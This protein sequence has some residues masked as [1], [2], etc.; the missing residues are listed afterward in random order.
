MATDAQDSVTKIPAGAVAGEAVLIV[1]FYGHS[2]RMPEV[3]KGL[4]R[5]LSRTPE[6]DV[7]P[8][9]WTD[10]AGKVFLRRF[11]VPAAHDTMVVQLALNAPG[12]A[13]E[14]WEAARR[15]L[16]NLLDE[17]RTPNRWWGYSLTYQAVL[18]SGMTA[19]SAL[20]KLLPAIRTFSSSRRLE[21]LAQADISGGKLWLLDIPIWEEGLKAAMVY[22]ALSPPEGEEALVGEIYGPGA[23]L[24]MP[25]LIAHKGYHQMRQHRDGEL[26][27]LYETSVTHLRNA[28]EQL[29]IVLEQD[30]AESESL[31][32]LARIYHQLNSVAMRLNE[33]YVGLTRQ[34][35]NYEWWEAQIE[36]N[37]VLDYHRQQLKTAT[38]ELELK[39]KE[40]QHALDTADRAVSLAQVQVDKAQENMQRQAAEEREYRRRRIEAWVAAVA[41]ALALPELMSQRVTGALLGPLAPED[42]PTGVRILLAAQLGIIVLVALLVGL[43]VNFLHGKWRGR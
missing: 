27:N 3:H 24:L 19:D 9:D 31:D 13:N 30:K 42:D 6:Q 23:T 2:E 16:E 22:V 15:R 36:D 12:E 26:E 35:Q 7:V 38:L 5:S 17:R 37:K 21:P 8:D 43:A 41:I 33:L 29:L 11:D 14:A 25:D 39:T 20:C 28:T 32:A 40:L 1:T 4:Y 34:S 10:P 18:A